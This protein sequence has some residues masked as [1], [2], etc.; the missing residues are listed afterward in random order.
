M[1][2]EVFILSG[3]VLSESI[4]VSSVKERRGGG[5]CYYSR[6]F[7]VNSYEDKK[8]SGEYQK[9]PGLDPPWFPSE[10][11]DKSEFWRLLY[12]L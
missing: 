11:T 6:E 1:Q 7:Q 10:A 4:R 2:G 12:W 5:W 3:S 9:E 8:Y